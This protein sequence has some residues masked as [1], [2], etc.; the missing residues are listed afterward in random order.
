MKLQNMLLLLLALI[1]S[2]AVNSQKVSAQTT[3]S[4]RIYQQITQSERSEFI[5]WCIAWG[6]IFA[7]GING[8]IL[9]RLVPRTAHWLGR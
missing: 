1:L 5:A 8:Y 9:Y 2:L 4:A 6:S 7:L 3:A